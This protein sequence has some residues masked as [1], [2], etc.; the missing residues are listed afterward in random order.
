[1]NKPT[2]VNLRRMTPRRFADLVGSINFSNR[3]FYD[4][5]KTGV[6]SGCTCGECCRARARVPDERLPTV[7][8]VV[9]QMKQRLRRLA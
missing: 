9:V 4:P 5:R 6:T 2:I 3:T 8:E 1:M 7:D